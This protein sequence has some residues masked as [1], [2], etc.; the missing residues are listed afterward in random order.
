MEYANLDGRLHAVSVVGG[1]TSMHDLGTIDSLLPDIDGCSHALHRLNRTQGSAASRA[2]S[3]DVAR[4]AHG[5]L[6]D[7]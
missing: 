2:R 1:R 3:G 7:A 6:A 5:A 4:C